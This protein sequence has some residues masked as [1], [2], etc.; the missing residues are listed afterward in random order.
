MPKLTVRYSPD[1]MVAICC[2][3]EAM[4]AVSGK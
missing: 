3:R 4:A 2:C 1:S